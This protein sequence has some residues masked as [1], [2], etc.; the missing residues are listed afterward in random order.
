MS[1]IGAGTGANLGLYPANCRV[2]A[3][4]LRYTSLARAQTRL[5]REAAVPFL[6]QADA[7]CL[8][9]AND[10]FDV[11]VSTLALCSLH[12]PAQGLTEI[13]RVLR[14]GG[15]FLTIEHVRSSWGALAACQ[16]AAMPLWHSLAHGC[17]LNRN[18]QKLILQAGFVPIYERVWLGRSVLFAIYAIDRGDA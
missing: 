17:H 1:W 10:C 12:N 9:F 15:R 16:D 14:P 13:S 2:T 6:V 18:T 8:P 7:E 4:D 5:S 3:I 11:A